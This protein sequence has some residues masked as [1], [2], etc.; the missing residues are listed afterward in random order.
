[1]KRLFIILFGAGLLTGNAVAQENG[2][3]VEPLQTGVANFLTL[4]SD[5]RSAAMGGAG[6]ALSGHAQP[7]FHNGATVLG[8]GAAT[9]GAAYT[10]A[11]W[12]RDFRSGYQ[13]HTV[14][15]YCRLND[16]HAVM[17]GFRYLGY[18]SLTDADQQKI[19]AKEW[20]LEAGYAFQVL[21]GLSVSATA[22]YVYS[23]LGEING[24]NGASTAAFDVGVFYYR[25][26]PGTEDNGEWSVGLQAANFGPQMSFVSGK[27][28]LPATIKAGGAVSLPFLLLHRVTLTADVLYRTLPSDVRSM[29]VSAGAEY[30]LLDVLYLRGGYHYGDKKK[31]DYSY[32]TAGIGLSMYGVQLDFSW[33]FANKDCTFRNTWWMTVSYQW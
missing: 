19:K 16:R 2:A 17:G 15:G 30:S 32:E 7:V 27:E 3:V 11:P 12:M 4:P 28:Y 25:A 9:A 8:A 18:P 22:R 1:M 6:I 21:E 33:L 23:A 10:F 13:L 14:G 29:G 31:A 24:N 26:F 20:T 5:A